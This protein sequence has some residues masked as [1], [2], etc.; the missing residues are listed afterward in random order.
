LVP[1]NSNGTDFDVSYSTFLIGIHCS[2]MIP[3]FGKHK[4]QSFD[5]RKI[6]TPLLSFGEKTSDAGVLMQPF[7]VDELPQ[8]AAHEKTYRSAPIDK[9]PSRLAVAMSSH[10]RCQLSWLDTR[11]RHSSAAVNLRLDVYTI[12]AGKCLSD[13]RPMAF[14]V[15]DNS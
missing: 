15:L 9:D 3:T 10:R 12:A 13:T 4:N 7:A 11:R 2:S 5:T 1:N 14:W 6:S 8:I